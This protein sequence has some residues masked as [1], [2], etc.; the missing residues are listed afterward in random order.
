MKLAQQGYVTIVDILSSLT[1]AVSHQ[2]PLRASAWV[3]QRGPPRILRPVDGAASSGE[4][5]QTVQLSCE[6]FARPVPEGMVG[7]CPTSSL[8]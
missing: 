2:C 3:Y 1:E 5:G 8:V 7:P 6:A 4:V